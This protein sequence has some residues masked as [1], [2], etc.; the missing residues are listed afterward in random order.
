MNGIHI[1]L[2]DGRLRR[3]Y[4][5]LVK[6]H[7]R[8]ATSVSAGLA[9]LPG[10]GRAATCAQALWRF[11]ANERV[12]LPALIEPPRELARQVVNGADYS[13]RYVLLA[14]DWSKLT[15]PAHRSKRDQVG[16]SHERDRGY[17]LTASLL[18]DAQ[19]GVPVAPLELQLWLPRECTR[20]GRRS[21]LRRSAIWSRCCRRCERRGRGGCCRKSCM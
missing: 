12:T 17:E 18:V 21:S 10:D 9:S 15:Y 7:F 6:Q 16:V 19:R 3:R 2:L 8:A 13:S 5:A 20:L 4:A 11:L 1:R 14:H